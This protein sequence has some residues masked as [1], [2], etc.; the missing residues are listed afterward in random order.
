MIYDN[1]A[2]FG[3]Y[4]QTFANWYHYTAACNNRHNQ[5][6]GNGIAGVDFAQYGFVGAIRSFEIV[7]SPTEYHPHLHCLFLMKKGLNL[8]QLYPNGKFSIFFKV[9]F[10]PFIS[11]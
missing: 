11:K 7:I 8:V 6:R 10:L 2:L 1:R 9:N 4:R 5:E 3:K